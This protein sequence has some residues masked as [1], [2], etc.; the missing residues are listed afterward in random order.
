MSSIDYSKYSTFELLDVKKNIDSNSANY[1]RLM[2]ELLS[3]EDE[4]NSIKEQN[5]VDSF[6]FAEGRVKIIGYFQVAASVAILFYYLGSIFDGSASILSTVVALP[7]VALNGIAGFTIIKE[8]YKYYWL[9]VLNQGLQIPS[10]SLG[11]ISASYS[12]LGGAY[13]YVSWNTE[14]LFGATAT[15]SP[16][17]SFYQ[18]TGNISTQSISIDILAIVFIGALLTV[19]DAKSTANK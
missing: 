7:L 9:S 6:S 3:R 19:S 8:N 16:G 4:I 18:Y 5:E 15:F 11:A 2:S 1:E 17:F 12:G 10:I 13:V 14:F